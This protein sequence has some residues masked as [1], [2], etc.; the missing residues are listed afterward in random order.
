MS[1]NNSVLKSGQ[2]IIDLKSQLKYGDYITLGEILGCAPDAAK[3]R[4][5][6]G[7]QQAYDALCAIV[8][9][10]EELKKEFQNQKS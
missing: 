9:M 10:R 2:K 8:D 7:N 1:K 4:F 5:E 6:R 3:K